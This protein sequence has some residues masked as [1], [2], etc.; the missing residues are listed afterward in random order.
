[1][2]IGITYDLKDD[3]LKEGL[4]QEQAA[5]FDEE[6]TI[7]T[8]TQCLLD[9]GYEVERIGN[10]KALTYQLAIGKKWDLVFNICEGKNGY[11]REAIVP[12]ILEL[13]E[14]PY[15]FSDP[16]TLSLALHKGMTKTI[17]KY[18]DLQTADFFVINDLSEVTNKSYTYPLFVK[19]V[20]EGTSKGID[21]ASII[22]NYDE[23][24]NKC[25]SLINSFNQPVLVE[26]FLPGDEY[27][28]AII[29]TGKEARVLGTLK[30]ILQE[31]AC[32]TIYSYKNKK[33]YVELVQYEYVTDDK[34][35]RCEELALKSW[36]V[37][38]CRDG[39]RVDIKLDKDGNPN[40]LEV[41]P[42]AGL[43]PEVSDIPILCRKMGFEYK[44]LI[45]QI[46]ESA[47]R[48]V[49]VKCL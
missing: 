29:G 25:R 47:L 23:F 10:A 4:T 14:I 7:M 41:N 37:L 36:R 22:Y 26:S 12:S 28:V 31:K 19:P 6:I 33:D 2:K 43:N 46:M 45:K 35:L 30:I 15:T 39:G 16:L 49:K 44:E 9:L 5:E 17:L 42:L 8:I 1:M 18:N 40:F 48:R 32:D 38:N 27:T 24:Y 20:A 3:Y 34:A 21:N 13:Y 11:S